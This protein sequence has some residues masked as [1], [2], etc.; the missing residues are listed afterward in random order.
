MGRL[1]TPAPIPP[2]SP[3]PCCPRNADGRRIA[4]QDTVFEKNK[5]STPNETAVFDSTAPPSSKTT[6]G[7]I[8]VR[9]Q[10]AGNLLQASRALSKPRVL[11][12]ARHP[13]FNPG[14]APS[15]LLPKQR[16]QHL[17]GIPGAPVN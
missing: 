17:V 10:R 9:A 8:G 2:L 7:F 15:A 6:D 4:Q 12:K 14:F 3:V 16:L 13:R 5:S 1:A 11:E